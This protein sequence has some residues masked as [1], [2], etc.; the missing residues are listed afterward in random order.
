MN[1]GVSIVRIFHN[2]DFTKNMSVLP[3]IMRDHIWRHHAEEMVFI[4]RFCCPPGDF[5]NYIYFT[6][7]PLWEVVFQ[8]RSVR[9]S[10]IQLRAISQ[11]I[12]Q[13]SNSNKSF[14][15]MYLKFHSNLP[16]ANG[17]TDLLGQLTGDFHVG[18]VESKLGRLEQ[19]AHHNVP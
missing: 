14:K 13:P 2:P 7:R 3:L 6:P 16:G 18:H 15:F 8:E 11:E 9:S 1:Y 10:N 4:E 12:P 17:L 5:I 19:A